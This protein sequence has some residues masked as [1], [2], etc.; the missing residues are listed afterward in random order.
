MAGVALDAG[1]VT[2]DGVTLV[3]GTGGASGGVAL[4]AGTG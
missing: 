1:A 3:A 2:V 4:D